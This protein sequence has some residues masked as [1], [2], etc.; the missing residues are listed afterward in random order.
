MSDA[1]KSTNI[2]LRAIENDLVDKD[3]VINACLGALSESEVHEM[4]NAND[5]PASD[6]AHLLGEE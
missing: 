3:Y 1:R 5:F 2:L 4:M 6:L